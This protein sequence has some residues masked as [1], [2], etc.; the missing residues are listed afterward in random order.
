MEI[1]ITIY[2]IGVILS[3]IIIISKY[4]IHWKN[5]YNIYTRDIIDTISYGILSWIMVIYSLLCFIHEHRIDIIF[6]GKK[7][8]VKKEKTKKR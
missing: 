1:F 5:G 6:K 8:N 4:Y 3:L 2:L 7:Q